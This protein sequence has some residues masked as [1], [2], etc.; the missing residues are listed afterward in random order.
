MPNLL[1]YPNSV[2]ITATLLCFAVLCTAADRFAPD[3]LDPKAAGMNAERLAAIPRRMQEFVTEGKTAGIV[4]VIARHGHVASFEAVGFQDG[5]KPMSKDTIFRIASM[6]KPITCA[7]IMLLVDEGRLSVID[8]VEKFL[9]E[10]K[11]LRL[12]PCGARTSFYCNPIVPARPINLED[13]MT[14]TSGLPGSADLGSGARPNSLA[15][16]AAAGAKTKLLFEP[17]TNWSY[18]NIGYDILGRVIEVVSGQSFHDFLS[19]HIFEPLHMRD[20]SFFL[21]PEKRQRLAGL[22]TYQEGHLK[23]VAADVPAQP[24]AIPSPAGGLLSTASDM[25]RFNEMMRNRGELDGRRILSMAAVQLMTVPH[26]GEIK[27]GWVPGVGHGYGYEVVREPSGMFRY[28]SLGSYVKGGAYRTYEWVDPQKD[29]VGILLMQRTNGD[30][31]VTD[32]LN[33]FM[34]MSAAAI[35]Q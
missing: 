6:T 24:P 21:P 14:H 4:T 27:A 34:T 16:L 8:P 35:E 1:Y 22:Y 17:G 12:N 5:R 33:S 31:D 28:N 25:L 18:S 30:T 2:K 3:K 29:L 7:A 23:Q 32:E 15:D 13:L 9:P 10:Y 11:N 26:T 19:Q 20:T